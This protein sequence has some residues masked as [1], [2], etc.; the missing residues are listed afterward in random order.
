METSLRI[1]HYVPDVVVSTY[2]EAVNHPWVDIGPVVASVFDQVGSSMMGFKLD[3][4][5]NT[6]RESKEVVTFK[7][8]DAIGNPVGAIM[9]GGGSFE[10][11]DFQELM[12]FP[13]QELPR[14]VRLWAGVPVQ[15]GNTLLEGARATASN[16][17][18]L[19]SDLRALPGQF[20][21]M[22]SN[23]GGML[24]SMFGSSGGS[25]GGNGTSGGGSSYSTV[26]SLRDAYANLN[27]YLRDAG[28]SSAGSGVGTNSYLC[29]GDAGMF[30]LHYHSDPDAVFWRGKLPLE[31]LYP[32]SWIPG[33]DEVSETL[34]NTWGSTY[35]RI[36]ET[37][38]SHPVKASA[39]LAERVASIINQ[40]YQP[41]IYKPLSIKADAE[42][43]YVYFE[44]GIYPKWQP[45]YPVPELGCMTFGAND[46]LN[47]FG[48]WGDFRT[49]S[50]YG[51]IWNYWRRYSCCERKTPI[52]LFTIP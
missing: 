23:A 40:K 44:R 17:V 6:A 46:S 37:V 24:Q 32:S 31:L 20:G 7:S 29:P 12:D 19:I 18:S 34:L 35:P 28:A 4:S 9:A 15:V 26:P 8:A 13:T 41:H 16:A 50:T 39:V 10:F 33:L 25:T 14:I 2:N 22:I 49:S 1:R 51:Y 11:V 30:S 21:G 27:Q 45:V 47:P 52:F 48:S 36:G 43:N 5:A 3:S 38:Q 42:R